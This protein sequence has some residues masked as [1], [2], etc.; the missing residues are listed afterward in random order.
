[1]HLKRDKGDTLDGEYDWRK[2]VY[3]HNDIV[4]DDHMDEEDFKQCAVPVTKCHYNKF[5]HFDSEEINDCKDGANNTETLEDLLNTLCTEET[6]CLY[7][8]FFKLEFIVNRE[9]Y[10]DPSWKRQDHCEIKQAQCAVRDEMGNM[11]P[12]GNGCIVSQ[13]NEP[14]DQTFIRSQNK[15][16]E[17]QE[18]SNKNKSGEIY[19]TECNI[20][21]KVFRTWFNKKQ[22]INTLS[23]TDPYY[24]TG[25]YCYNAL[26]PSNEYGK[27]RQ[28][29]YINNYDFCIMPQHI[30]RETN[31]MEGLQLVFCTY[32]GEI[33]TI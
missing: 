17:N 1:M 4:E 29:K 9:E 27:F 3:E 8:D 23:L 26:R 5:K 10:Y 19:I 14:F 13:H 30:D 25:N 22:H 24:V 28:E 21:G 6:C 18:E 12:N 31:I 11:P 7:I 32:N 2:I 33:T 16:F 15:V 20:K